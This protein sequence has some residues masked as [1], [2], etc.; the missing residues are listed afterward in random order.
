VTIDKWLTVI[1]KSPKTIID[2]VIR[3]KKITNLLGEKYSN[4]SIYPDFNDH[5]IYCSVDK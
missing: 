5:E 1:S 4:V 3:R 2:A